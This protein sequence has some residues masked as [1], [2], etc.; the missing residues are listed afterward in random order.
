[1]GSL[2]CYMAAGGGDARQPRTRTVVSL[3]R[4]SMHHQPVQCWRAGCSRIGTGSRVGAGRTNADAECI[5]CLHKV[6]FMVSV[7]VSLECDA[8]H[9]FL[10]RSV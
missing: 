7:V 10:V 3:S 5:G 6:W 1:V 4:C 9:C 2:H 8:A